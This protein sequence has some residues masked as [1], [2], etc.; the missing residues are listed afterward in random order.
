LL[1]VWIASLTLAMTVLDERNP[2]DVVPASAPGPQRERNCA[3][4]GGEDSRF[5]RTADALYYYNQR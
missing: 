1:A 2:N 5:G 4:R 3:H